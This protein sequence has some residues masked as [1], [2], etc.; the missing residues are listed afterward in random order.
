M[1]VGVK[2]GRVACQMLL[3]SQNEISSLGKLIID[4]VW[5]TNY[6][7]EVSLCISNKVV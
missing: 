2:D 1:T 3:P 6:S 7:S 5:L 4:I